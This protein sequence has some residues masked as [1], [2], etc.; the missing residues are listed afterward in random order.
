M[1]EIVKLYQDHPV[2]IVERNGEPWF[3][4]KDVCDVLKIKNSRT[5]LALLE[6]DERDVHTVDTLSGEQEMTIVSEAGLYSLIL[7]SRK[8]EAKAF[9]RWVTH[10]VL[11]S[12]RKTGAY[13]TPNLS[14]DG[15]QELVRTISTKFSGL[16]QMNAELREEVEYLLQF[17]PKG[18]YGELSKV[19]GLP[20]WQFRSGSIVSKNGRKPK[21]LSPAESG[22]IQLDLFFDQLPRTIIANAL[23]VINVNCPKLLTEVNG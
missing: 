14:V 16:I 2:R 17:T 7:R 4:A 21:R 11:P 15:L 13:L 23:N 1:N 5:S 8:L 10:E 22:F 9:K 20:R 3:V 18:K 6:V 19:N 12:I